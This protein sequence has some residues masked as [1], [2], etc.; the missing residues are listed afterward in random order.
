[1]H[2]AWHELNI[3]SRS[4]R[5]RLRRAEERAKE[6]RRE[7][8]RQLGE[9]AAEGEGRGKREVAGGCPSISLIKNDAPKRNR[10]MAVDGRSR[11]LLSIFQVNRYLPIESIDRAPI[12]RELSGSRVFGANLAIRGA[13][14]M[15]TWILGYSRC[16]SLTASLSNDWKDNG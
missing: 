11:S 15:P 2:N 6:M 5:R 12:S 9:I 16:P 3:R 13:S 4:E 1:V 10:G 8:K 14:C 7:M